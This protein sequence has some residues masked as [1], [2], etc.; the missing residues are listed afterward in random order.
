MEAFKFVVI[1]P[2]PTKRLIHAPMQAAYVHNQLRT[3]QGHA[4]CFFKH[5]PYNTDP[6]KKWKE[7]EKKMLDV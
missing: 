6:K 3:S 4:F 2:R 1:I 5:K 7:K